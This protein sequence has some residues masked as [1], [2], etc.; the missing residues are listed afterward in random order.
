LKTIPWCIAFG[1]IVAACQMV[2]AGDAV[3]AVGGNWPQWRGPLGVGVAPEADPP[4]EWNEHEGKNIRWKCELPG[5]GH[6]TPIVWG[7]R[8]FVTAA[9]PFGERLKPRFSKAPGAHD[10]VPVTQRHRFVVIGID[11]RSGRI[12]WQRTVHEA[13]PHEGYHNTGSLASASPVTDGEQV[14]AHFGSYGLYA[15]DFDGNVRWEAR[16][17]LMQPLHGHGEGSSPALFGQSLVINWDHEAGSFVVA[18]DKRTGK[19]LWKVDRDEITSWS[20]PIV[21]EHAGRAQVIVNGTNRMRGYDLETGAVIWECGGLSSNVVASPVSANG[22]VFAGSSYEKR[23]FLAVR[24]DGAKGDITG[25]KRVAWT[26][27]RG[28]PYVPSPLLYGD[29]LYFLGHYQGVLSRVH[30]PTGEDRP[31]PFRL[32]GI[33]DVYASPIGAA[34]RIYI[35]DRDGTTLVLSHADKPKVLAE[36]QLDE[37]FNASGSIAGR[38]LFLRGERHLYCLAEE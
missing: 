10:N 11:R 17:G 26:R 22:M 4:V 7:D 27:N 28:T 9:I 32:A 6:S 35:T 25:T 20:S 8:V 2:A 30:G 15:L 18:I 37:T 34:G 31:A 3:S 24:L 16:F 33:E 19:Q 23:A 36:N 13:L 1:S 38:D 5:R 29:A 21:I 14:Y 12:L